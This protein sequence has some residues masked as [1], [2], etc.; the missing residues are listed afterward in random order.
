MT[1]F[2]CTFRPLR[3]SLRRDN[4]STPPFIR[5]SNNHPWRLLPF[6]THAGDPTAMSDAQASLFLNKEV[7]AVNANGTNPRQLFCLPDASCAC[8]LTHP[9]AH[10]SVAWAS[11]Y[12]TPPS[13][14]DAGSANDD[15][16]RDTQSSSKSGG[17][18]SQS[19]ATS[20]LALFN[21]GSGAAIP[22]VL[23][24]LRSKVSVKLSAIRPTW[25][26]GTACTV[27]DL[28]QHRNLGVVDHDSITISLAAHDAALLSV[29]CNQQLNLHS[30]F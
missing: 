18:L 17:T 25:G 28:W 9:P 7:L 19:S 29:T 11:D 1:A 14:V 27:R 3:H 4:A 26:V 24:G 15:G 5:L 6:P 22:S 23:G 21:V 30:E 12:A 2:A 16:G 10:A 13:L 20:F 8:N